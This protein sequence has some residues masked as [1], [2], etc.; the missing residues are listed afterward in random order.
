MLHK[1]IHFTRRYNMYC[2]CVFQLIDYNQYKVVMALTCMYPKTISTN[3]HTYI[4]TS[5]AVINII[6]LYINYICED[7]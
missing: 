6:I 7:N 3:I 1:N 2:T 5:L 4:H